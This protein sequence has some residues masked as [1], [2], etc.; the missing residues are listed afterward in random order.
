M[1]VQFMDCL[2]DLGQTLRMVRL[3]K[4][5]RSLPAEVV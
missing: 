1:T 4:E 5:E 3:K 2:G